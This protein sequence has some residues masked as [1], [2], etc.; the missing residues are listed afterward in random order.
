MARAERWHKRV[1]GWRTFC[2]RMSWTRRRGSALQS[3]IDFFGPAAVRAMIEPMPQFEIPRTILRSSVWPRRHRQA[4]GTGPPGPVC[5]RRAVSVD[6]F[7]AITLL[8]KR[9]VAG[10]LISV[11]RAFWREHFIT[12]RIRRLIHGGFWPPP[13]GW[14]AGLLSDGV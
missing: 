14:C 8:S 2:F 3:L 13:I 11:S 9:V 4:S 7:R 5:E 1:R 6:T 12:D 10:Q